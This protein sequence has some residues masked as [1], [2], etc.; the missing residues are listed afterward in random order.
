MTT[1]VLGRC[2]RGE[3]RVVQWA[4]TLAGLVIFILFK[5]LTASLFAQATE[6]ASRAAPS[7]SMV[8]GYV[9]NEACARCHASIYETFKHTPMAHAS[10]PATENLMPADFTH[11]KSGVH[12]R[13]QAEGGAAWLS[14]DRPGDP[15]ITGK[16]ELL[17]FIG[18][19]HRGRTYLFDVDGFLFESPVNWYADRHIWDMAPA[20]GDAREI[21]LNLPA[22]TTCLRCHTSGMELPLNGTENKYPTPP[23]KQDGVGCESCH[24]PGEAHAKGAD[25]LNPMKLPADRRDA[26]C[27]QCHLEGNV[28]IERP[29]RHAGEFRPGDRLDDYVRHY[30]LV[31]NQLSGLGANSQ[32][33]AL[34]ESACKKKS[35]D[36]MSCMSCHDPHFYPSEGERASYYRGKCLACHG[37]AFGARH[38]VQN[39][40]CI[41]CHMPA[42]LS[43]DIAHTEV[44]DHHIRRRPE[45]APQLLQET[46]APHTP[47]L[48]PFPDSRDAENDV[49]DRALAWQSLANDGVPEAASQ[50][51]HLLRSAARKSPGDPVVL[52]G[53]AFLELQRGKDDHARELY[54]KALALDPTL[55]D[56]ATNLGVLEAKRG[57]LQRAVS[58]WQGAFN[59]APGKSSIGMNLARVFCESGQINEARSYVLRV[60]QFNPDRAEARKLLQHLNANPPGCGQ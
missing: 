60:L 26:V 11:A 54:Q 30:V 17:Y 5:T 49:R 1:S 51:A 47:S 48:V 20:Y 2:G 45:L 36:S 41:A 46:G 13:I 42:S 33:E 16:R 15:A 37:A 28:A 12:Y 4:P 55:I 52:S 24:G 56:A 34:S 57:Q 18:S 44:N 21:P 29:G 3:P 22:Y 38:H 50:A 19:G 10:G 6:S 40:D 8:A 23:F 14:F 59:R 43:A 32:F 31:G 27:M 7:H 35:G 25:I 39:H 58:L 9:G 53:L